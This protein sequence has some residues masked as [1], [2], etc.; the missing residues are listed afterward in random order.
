MLNFMLTTAI[1]LLVSLP[2]LK[3]FHS[4]VI[5]KDTHF[6]IYNAAVIPCVRDHKRLEG[7]FYPQ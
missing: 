2:I 3:P 5:K 7:G 6:T 4:V 1:Y